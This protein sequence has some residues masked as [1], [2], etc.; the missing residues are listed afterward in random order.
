[1][2]APITVVIAGEP[3]AKARPRMTRKGFAYTPS[4]TRKYE[5]HGRLAAQV[6]MD[7]RPPLDGPVRIELL[8]ELPVPASWSKRKTTDAITGGI[9]PTSRPDTDNYIKS[10]LDAINSIVVAD[11]SQAVEIHAKKKFGIAPKMLITVF[12]LSAASSNRRT[13]P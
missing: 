8:I 11:D 5:A 13:S 10:A 1:M 2:T 4:H 9:Q 6:A 12:P 3:V 7:G